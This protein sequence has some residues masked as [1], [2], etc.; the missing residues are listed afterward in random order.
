MHCVFKL[1]TS[2][3]RI[4]RVRLCHSSQCPQTLITEETNRKQLT[5]RI[6]DLESTVKEIHEKCKSYDAIFNCHHK[7]ILIIDSKLKQVN[8]EI[9]LILGMFSL[10]CFQIYLWTKSD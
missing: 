4:T 7:N 10:V 1:S 9:I 5:Q 3:R 6:T 8:E 2:V